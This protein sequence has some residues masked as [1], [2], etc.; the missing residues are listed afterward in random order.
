MLERFDWLRSMILSDFLLPVAEPG[1][2]VLTDGVDADG[3]GTLVVL[4]ALGIEELILDDVVA[5]C[6]LLLLVA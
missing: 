1:C 2:R 6:G 4:D 3:L 5:D